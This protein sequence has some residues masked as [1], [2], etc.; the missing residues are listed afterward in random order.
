MTAIPIDQAAR[1]LSSLTV[2]TSQGKPARASTEEKQRETGQ[3]SQG[4]SDEGRPRG[5]RSP[6]PDS[7]MS[8]KCPHVLPAG[9]AQTGVFL[10]SIQ[11]GPGQSPRRLIP[12]PS[13]LSPTVFLLQW[14]LRL[15][16][17]W[18]LSGWGGSCLSS[19][20]V[21]RS[22]RRLRGKASSQR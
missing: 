5:R 9:I 8:T 22:P 19:A 15:L 12:P 16:G 4:E 17:L 11:E 6:S 13:A 14:T 21:D 1:C 18:L 10:E 7:Q 20:K 3:R 2:R